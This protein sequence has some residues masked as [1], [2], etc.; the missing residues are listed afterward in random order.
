MAQFILTDLKTNKSYTAKDY[1]K[2][3][4]KTFKIIE[5]RKNRFLTAYVD[6]IKGQLGLFF[7]HEYIKPFINYEFHIKII[8]KN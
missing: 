6:Y 4:D 8:K 7:T 5:E 3:W 1:I 2:V